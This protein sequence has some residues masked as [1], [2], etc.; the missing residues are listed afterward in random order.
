MLGRSGGIVRCAPTDRV[1]AISSARGA[2]MGLAAFFGRSWASWVAPRQT[3][4]RADKQLLRSSAL[5]TSRRKHDSL[6][7]WYTPISCIL[8]LQSCPPFATP[9]PPY[10]IPEL[11]LTRSVGRSGAIVASHIATAMRTRCL[12]VDSLRVWECSMLGR[13]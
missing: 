13:L 2:G 3:V 5:K 12:V 10:L 6:F 9:P 11:Q 8:Y 4:L 7:G 1:A